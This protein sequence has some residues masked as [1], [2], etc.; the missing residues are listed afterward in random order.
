[1]TWSTGTNTAAKIDLIE[2][3]TTIKTFTS[4][5][6]S[7]LSFNWTSVSSGTYQLQAKATD[8]TGLANSSA[9]V[10]ITV[11]PA[12]NHPPAVAAI[13]ANPPDVDA[14]TTG[15][16]EYEGTTV[17]YSAS[18][19]DSDNDVLTWQWYYTRNGGSRI[20]SGSP[21]SA[22]GSGTAQVSF[23]YPAI[24]AG[25]NYVWILVVN[26]GHN[27]VVEANLPVTIISRPIS[28]TPP[29]S[30][31]DLSGLNNKTFTLTDELSFSYPVTGVTFGWV[32]AL[33]SSSPAGTG[34][35]PMASPPVAAGNDGL[36]TGM[37]S[38]ASAP[39]PTTSAPRFTPATAVFTAAVKNATHVLAPV[40]PVPPVCKGSL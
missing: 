23:S 38:K 3:G 10:T 19:S 37:T 32:F 2:N 14:T 24:S 7:P 4:P 36:T 40:S 16:Q 27:P 35:G 21:G 5:A 20:A 9:L 12:A 25:T 18:V 33:N 8:S 29:L 39:I 22:T 6:G 1:V 26:D 31:P 34:R 30:P 17:L 13:T 11:N 15:V 28:S